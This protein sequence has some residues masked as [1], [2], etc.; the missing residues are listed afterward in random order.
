MVSAGHGNVTRMGTRGPGAFDSDDA[1]DL[2]DTLTRQDPVN[3][4]REA[5]S[6]LDAVPGLAARQIQPE[7]VRVHAERS[8]G[9]QRDP[10]H[11][12]GQRED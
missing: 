2:L 1:L 11:G 10:L 9:L 3:H 6:Q 5:D 8:G 12:H 7:R 4:E